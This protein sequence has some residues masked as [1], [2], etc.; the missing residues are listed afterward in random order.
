MTNISMDKQYKTRDGRDVR[1]LC[2]DAE[3][4]NSVVFMTTYNSNRSGP[5]SIVAR[6]RADGLV[7]PM[8]EH[9]LDLIEVPVRKSTFYNIYKGGTGSVPQV[10]LQTA[11]TSSRASGRSDQWTGVTVEVI[12]ENDVPVESKLHYDSQ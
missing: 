12:H 4:T 8:Q 1:I 9:P 7:L 6:C 2:V 10:D 11:V 5:K 3:G